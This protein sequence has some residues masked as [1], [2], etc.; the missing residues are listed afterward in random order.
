M[1]MKIIGHRGAAGLA[2][3]NTL[4]ALAAGQKA[5]AY[6]LEFDIRLTK[7]Q[8]VVACHDADLSRVTGD[9]RRI[10][11]IDWHELKNMP[12]SE[13]L[14]HAGQTPLII[15]VKVKNMIRPLLQTIDEFPDSKITIASFKHREI[16]LLKSMR[17]D[18]KA[19]IATRDSPFDIILIARAIEADGLD[20]NFW[21]LN[22][23]TY[24]WALRNNLD[25]MVY[26]VNSR[27]VARFIHFFYPKVMICTNYPRNFKRRPASLAK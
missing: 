26:T 20:I 23:F 25:I 8:R 12:L 3:E 22:I 1:K 6:A 15:E 2:M 7:D 10:K 21:I 13:I 19:Y 17:P 16:A 9:N 5:G 18:I 11:N 27:L 14:A 4:G 24:Y